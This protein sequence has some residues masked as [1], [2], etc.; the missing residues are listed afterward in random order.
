DLRAHELAD[1]G[2]QIFGGDAD[3]LAEGI[4]ILSAYHPAYIDINMGCSV[5]KIMRSE[6]GAYLICEPSRLENVCRKAVAATDIPVTVKTRLG[7]THD[8]INVLEVGRVAE[9]CG[10]AAIALHGRT[11]S[12]KF[13]GDSKWEWIERLKEA[14]S[15]PV[16]G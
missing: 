4:R 10:I 8:N 14:V 12:D 11:V 13:G 1:T 15:I 16:L 5:P 3:L 7:P 9:A 2:I 6:G